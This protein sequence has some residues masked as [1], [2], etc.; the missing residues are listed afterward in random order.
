[1]NMIKINF[2]PELSR[3]DHG[4]FLNGGV[5]GYPQEVIAGVLVAVFGF[6]L[7]IH[8][9][10]GGIVLWK[11]MERNMLQVRWNSLAADKK[12]VDEVSDQIKAVQAKMT[13]VHPIMA[14]SN[15][16]WS[17]FIKDVSL[18]VPKGVALKQVSLEKGSLVISGSA[19]SMRKNEMILAGQFVATLK[20]KK[21]FADYF[22]DADVDYSIQR[23]ETLLLSVANFNLKAKLK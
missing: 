15:I 17:G 13:A 6:L 19:T 3:K 22:M 8:A 18:S 11:M 7:V 1:M 14:V 23:Q 2:V 10:L 4:G 20:Q 16:L 5:G 12:V 21:N 9:F